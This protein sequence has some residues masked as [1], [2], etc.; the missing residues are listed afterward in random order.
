MPLEILGAVGQGPSAV[1]RVADGI[2]IPPRFGRGGENIVAQW[3][4]FLGLEGRLFAANYGSGATGAAGATSFTDGAPVANLDVPTG[5]A[6][7]FLE[8]DVTITAMTGTVNILFLRQGSNNVGNGTSS[9]AAGGPTNL[10]SDQP[11]S[12]R[13]TARQVYTAAGNTQTNPVELWGWGSVVASP[14]QSPPPYI[15]EALNVLI[16]PASI[17]LYAVATTTAPSVKAVFK[18]AELPVSAVQ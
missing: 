7:V 2:Q 13:C 10:R 1:N 9:A 11:F 14:A 5:I 4:Q 12:S 8:L 15:P 17:A 3:R 6:V 16:G 18:W